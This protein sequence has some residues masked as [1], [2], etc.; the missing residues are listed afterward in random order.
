MQAAASWDVEVPNGIQ[1]LF[2]AVWNQTLILKNVFGNLLPSVQ[3]LKIETF[4]TMGREFAGRIFFETSPMCWKTYGLLAPLGMALPIIISLKCESSHL[5]E[6]DSL[7]SSVYLFA[8]ASTA[9][10]V[11]MYSHDMVLSWLVNHI[12]PLYIVVFLDRRL[13][14]KRE[15]QQ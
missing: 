9:T 8:C 4:S 2:N 7:Y 15:K 12:L 5:T 14:N 3:T 10:F 1:A 13:G 6:R 11:L